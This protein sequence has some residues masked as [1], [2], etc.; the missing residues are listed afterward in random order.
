MNY[1]L[2]FLT[3][4]I[5]YINGYGEFVQDVNYLMKHLL[6]IKSITEWINLSYTEKVKQEVK[7]MAKCGGKKGGK[8]KGGK[9]K[10]CGGGR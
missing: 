5:L 2:G 6:V 10:G 3:W 1:V 7:S 8:K 4:E 9:R